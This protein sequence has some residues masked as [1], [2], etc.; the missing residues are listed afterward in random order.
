MVVRAVSSARKHGIKLKPG[1]PTAA[2]GNCAFEAA[3]SNLNDRECFDESLSQSADFYRRI[4][5]TDMKNR[6][7][8]DQTWNIYSN[9]EWE[10]GWTEMLKSGVYVFLVT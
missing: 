8:N 4:W 1:T 5:M 9:S 3:T 2:D 7:V 10:A 6:T